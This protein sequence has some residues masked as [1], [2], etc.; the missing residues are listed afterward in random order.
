MKL[1]RSVALHL[2][3]VSVLCFSVVPVGCANERVSLGDG[4][5]SFVPPAGFKAWTEEQIKTKYI[6]GNPPQYVFANVTGTV[7]VAVTF[8]PARVAP[9]Q[10]QEY[11]ESMEQILPRL[12][13]G[14]EWV[15]REF[16]E[17]DGRKWMHLEMK[18][19]AIDTDI[20]NHLYSTSFNGKALIFGFNSTVKDYLKVKEKLLKSAQ[21]I[22]LSG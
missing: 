9:E 14:L 8:S 20:H 21:S 16:V 3:I 13:P 7:T 6:R 12:I 1:L 10:I 17:I 15:T 5:V 22:K 11:K 19:Y 4:R 2:F 18:S